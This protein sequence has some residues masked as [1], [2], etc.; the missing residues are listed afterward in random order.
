MHDPLLEKL[1]TKLESFLSLWTEH[2]RDAG[3][4]EHTTAKRQDCIDSFHGVL[5]SIQY[6]APQ[7]GVP[8]FAPLLKNAET[9]ARYMIESARKHRH[10][11]I[12]EGMYLGCFKTFIHS[13]EDIILTLEAD[14]ADKLDA[15]LK[16]RRVCDVMETAFISDGESSSAHNITERLQDVNRQLTLKK[17]RYENIFRS[18][19]DLVILSDVEGRILEVNPETEKYLSSKRLHGKPFWRFL[20]IDCKNMKHVLRKFPPDERH[21]ISSR[22]NRHVFILR[23]VPLSRVSLATPEYMLILSDIS[24]LVNHRQE[25]ERRVAERTAALSHSEEML[26]REKSQTDEM[27]VTLRNVMKNIETDQKDL[28]RCI[29]QKISSQLLPALEKIRN[30]SAPGVRSSFI[31]LVQEQ[32]IALTSGSNSELDAGMLKLSKT[33][34]RICGFI[35]AGC[36]SKEISDVMNLAFDTIRTHRKNIRKK[37]GLHGKNVNL[38]AFLANRICSLPKLE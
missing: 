20:R 4:L 35:Q 33:E 8:A 32:L 38:H 23:I 21:E 18:T 37:L 2:M 6:M 17:N 34:L 24:L 31:D 22:D 13:L 26:R 25:L 36:S 10:R 16:I 12:T 27:N 29:S 7:K 30:E 3:Y 19:S 5:K 28:E 1:N 9:S 11:G 14:A 15:I